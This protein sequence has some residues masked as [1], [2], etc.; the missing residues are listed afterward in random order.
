MKL[1][2]TIDYNLNNVLV[3]NCDR[4]ERCSEEALELAIKKGP[5]S[6]AGFTIDGIKKI[7]RNTFQRTEPIIGIVA[8]S[9]RGSI[10]K[11]LNAFES[12]ERGKGAVH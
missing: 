8:G 1:R 11:L 4:L 2:I 9:D 12:E 3:H 10:K 6:L 7:V 5:E